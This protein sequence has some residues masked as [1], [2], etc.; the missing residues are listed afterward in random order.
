[1]PIRI[2]L[3]A[4]AQAAEDLRRRDPVKRMF[5]VGAL[6]LVAVLAWSSYLQLKVMTANRELNGI[7]YKIASQTNEFQMVLTNEAKIADA[8]FKLSE[9]QKLNNARLLQGNLLNALQQ[10]S[11]ENV[12]LTHLKVDQAYLYTEGTSF[13]NSA[14]QTVPG[15]PA[16][17]TERIVVLLDGRDSSANPGDQVGKFKNALA[18]QPYFQEMLDKT[19]GIRLA[20]ESAPQVGPDG[21]N[22]VMFTLECHFPDKTR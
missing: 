17:A 5:F 10:V 11:V 2:N 1:M 20:T 19:N 22:F 4:E 13:K 18:K 14:G 3:L 12:Q 16:T 6:L 15:K 8:K 21:K 9:L 7:E